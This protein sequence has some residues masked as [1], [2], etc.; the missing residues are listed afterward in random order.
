MARKVIV[1]LVVIF[2]VFYIVSQPAAAA[3]ATRTILG[4]I[5][6]VFSGIVTFFQS[7]V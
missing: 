4:G 2:I 3:D 1:A 6:W 7:L 5:Q